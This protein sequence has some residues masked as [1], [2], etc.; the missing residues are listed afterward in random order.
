VLLAL[1]AWIDE[2][3][4][5]RLVEPNSRLGKAFAYLKNH[6]PGLTRFLDVPGVPLDNNQ[7]ERELKPA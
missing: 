7:T 4:D 2:H 1:R 3:L 5:A 6:W